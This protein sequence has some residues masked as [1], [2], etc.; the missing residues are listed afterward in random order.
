MKKTLFTHKFLPRMKRVESHSGN[1]LLYYR[2]KE[3]LFFSIIEMRNFIDSIITLSQNTQNLDHLS[4][5]FAR[6]QFW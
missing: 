1:S 2:L 6:V 3:Y 4:L 5:L